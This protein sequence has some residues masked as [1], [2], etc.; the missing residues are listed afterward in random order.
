MGFSRADKGRRMVGI[1]NG[2]GS[3]AVGAKVGVLV[4][5]GS[6]FVQETPNEIK[7]RI[8]A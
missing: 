3:L 1:G 4:K 5:E 7:I 2:L 8:L 6:N